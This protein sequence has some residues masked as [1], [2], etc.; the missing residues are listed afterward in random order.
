[1]ATREQIKEEKKNKKWL[2]LLLLL[3]LLLIVAIGVTVWSLF[4]R[5]KPT[6][7]P[8]YAPRQEEQY[9][10]DIGDSGD[11]KLPQAEGG[12]AVSLTYTTK[13]TVDLSDRMASLY[14]A[15]PSK[16]NQDIVL[17]IIVQDVVSSWTGWLFWR[18]PCPCSPPAAITAGSKSCTTSRTPTRRPS[19]TPRSP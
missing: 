13:V 7:T 18:R 11:E 8:D 2:L 6:L 19:S 9:V 12:G 15:N 4:F 16:S 3:L 17:Q 14:F 10:K 1:M 5:A